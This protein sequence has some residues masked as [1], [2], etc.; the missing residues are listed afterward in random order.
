M[1]NETGVGAASLCFALIA[2]AQLNQNQS[3]PRPGSA[4]LQAWLQ[5]QCL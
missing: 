4:P 3:N 1:E 5:Y 2:L